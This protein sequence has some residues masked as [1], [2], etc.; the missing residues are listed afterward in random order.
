M[1][2]I[3]F[4]MYRGDDKAFNVNVKD[5]DGNSVNLTGWR[6]MTTMKR[7]PVAQ[8]H[9]VD[10]SDEQATVSVDSPVLSGI[11]AEAGIYKL[12]LPN[13]QT[14]NLGAGLY[15]IDIQRELDG[16]YTTVLYGRVRVIADV[17]RRAAA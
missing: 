15:Y 16:L 2:A 7:S 3:L 4:E 14:V 5:S 6:F 11:D 17:T 1:T 10:T 13:A 8:S 9:I 12:L